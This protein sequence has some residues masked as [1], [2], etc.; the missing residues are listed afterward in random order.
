MEKYNILILFL[1]LNLCSIKECLAENFYR[2]EFADKNENARLIENPSLFLSERA[3]QRRA[4]YKIAVTDQDL[5]LSNQYLNML[6]RNGKVISKSKWRNSCVMVASQQS[7]DRIHEEPF[8]KKITYLGSTKGIK[9]CGKGAEFISDTFYSRKQGKDNGLF[10]RK[11]YGK[12]YDQIH[13]HKGERLHQMG[14][15]GSGRLIAV[16]DAGFKGVNELTE[17]DQARIREVKDF[18][19][20]REEGYGRE[21]HGTQVLSTMLANLSGSFIGTAPY[22]DYILLRSE[23]LSYELPVE[24]DFWINAVEYADSCGVDIISSSLGYQNFDQDFNI[25]SQDDIGQNRAISTQVANMAFEKGMIVV[26]SAGNERETDWGGLGFP[27]DAQKAFTVG[28]ID[29]EKNISVFSSYGFVNALSIK[30]NVVSL[31]TAPVTIY[32]NGFYCREDG[33][34]FATPVIAGLIACLWEALPDKT[35]EEIMELVQAASNQ[36][37]HPDSSFGYGI[38]NMEKAYKIGMNNNS[39]L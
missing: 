36:I 5:P 17:F 28:S 25:Y 1:F 37:E 7:V 6:S 31:G 32:P 3:I 35:N 39:E 23:A 27:A 15:L 2:I 33:T 22:A 19:Y 16:I 11:N 12:S 26:L 8:I 14:Y 10:N 13:L 38:P 29:K 18:G 4:K 30:P 34:S 9:R 21:K 20:P 24:E